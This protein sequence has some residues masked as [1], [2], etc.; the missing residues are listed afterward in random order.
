MSYR[1]L[2]NDV[3]NYMAVDVG[4]AEVAALIAVGELAVI[5]AEKM[6]DGRI[7]VVDVHGSRHPFFIFAGLRFEDVAVGIG[8]VV[9]VVICSAI[10]D[11]GFNTATSHPGGEAARVVIASVSIFGKRSLAVG[12]STKFSAPD[13]ESFI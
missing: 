6:K 12:S 5:D 1:K 2:S 11:T 7:A 10:S 4:E 8:N 3:V 13:N 9:A